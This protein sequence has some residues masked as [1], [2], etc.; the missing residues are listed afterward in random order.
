MDLMG[1]VVGHTYYFLDTVYPQVAAVRGW[2]LTKIM[3]TPSILHY[4]FATDP[5]FQIIDTG[6]ST[7]CISFASCRCFNS[8]LACMPN[9]FSLVSRITL[10]AHCPL[11]T[12][13][14]IHIFYF[15]LRR[16]WTTST[17]NDWPMPDRAWPTP[18]LPQEPPLVPRQQCLGTSTLEP[19]PPHLSN[20]HRLWLPPVETEPT[21][22]WTNSQASTLNLHSSTTATSTA[23][24]R[25]RGSRSNIDKRTGTHE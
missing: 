22:I 24:A 6:V 18:L 4:V 23:A 16:Y 2:S 10:F 1:I 20:K 9:R 19:P 11:S 21:R 3:V 25:L 5:G 13:K 8:A 7:D 15:I 17:T 12:G 14:N